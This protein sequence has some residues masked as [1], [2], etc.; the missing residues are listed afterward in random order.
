VYIDNFEA[1]HPT[2]TFTPEYL[3][4]ISGSLLTSPYVAPDLAKGIP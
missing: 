1:L 3:A 4:Y 2:E